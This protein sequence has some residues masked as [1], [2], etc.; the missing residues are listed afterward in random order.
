M[1]KLLFTIM[2]LV[3]GFALTS[4]SDNDDD[5]SI[6]SQPLLS[7]GSVITGSADVTSTQALLHGTVAGL[8]GQSASA[9]TCGFYYGKSQANLDQKVTANS[10][11]EFEASI[12]G[13]NADVFYYQAFVTLQGRVTYKGE[14]KSLILTD[15][16]AITGEVSDL[17]ANKA[18]FGGQLSQ[19]PA[20]AESGIVVS[21][22]AGDERV[23]AGVR[24][25]GTTEA[26]FRVEAKGFLPATTYYYTAYLDLGAGVVYGETRQFI[27]PDQTFDVNT[28]MVDLGL[29]TKWAK[30][31]LG[32]STETEAGALLGFG[33]ITGFNTGIMLEE[34]AKRNIYRTA[35]DVANRVWNGRATMP[36]ID[37]YEELFRCCKV[38]WQEMDGVA[39]YRFTGPN[40]NS[41]FMPAAGS[42]TKANISGAG[43]E[44]RYLSGSSNIVSEFDKEGNEKIISGD[45]RFAMSYLFNASGNNRTTTPTYQALSVRPVSTAKNIAFEKAK[46]IG[47]WEIDL[48]EDGKFQVF[49]GPTYFYGAD[50]SWETVTNSAP[51]VGDSWCWDADF[52]GN[53]W[54]VGGS[55]SNCKG[56]MTFREDG[57]VEVH[58]ISADG[59]ETVENGTYTINEDKKSIDFEGVKILAPTNF[60]EGYT[61]NLTTGVRILSLTDKGLQLGVPRTNGEGGQLSVNYIHQIEKY[62]YTAKLTC[63]GA[64]GDHDASDGWDSAIITIPGGND[65][66][67]TYTITFHA[68]EARTNGKVYVIDIPDFATVYPN[69]FMRVDAIKADGRDV[70]FDQNKFYFG[71]IEG[72]GTYRIEM[73]NI[74][75][76]GHNDS[77]DG[78]GDSPFRPEGGATTDETNLGFTDTFEVTFT[79][80]SLD[81]NLAFNVKQS[82]VGL[83][84]PWAMPGNWGKENP[85]A[86]RVVLGDDHKYRVEGDQL[87]LTLT[88]EECDGG[89]PPS[90]GAMN[91]V[92]VVGIRN[93]FPAFAADLLSVTC[94][95]NNVPF[96]ASKLI[97]GDI[98]GNGNYRIE[99]HNIWGA[100]TAADP[101]FG[102]ARVVEGNNC[103][104]ALGFTSS[105]VYTIGNYSPKLFSTPW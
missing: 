67:G 41:I 42:R 29:S 64:N 80:V 81:A 6:S 57:T 53:T 17:T 43:T 20:D 49:H 31:N 54:A 103:V 79:I 60:N 9:Y 69:A 96:D 18:T 13:Q 70:P 7:E 1:K 19:F 22:I 51:V 15:A 82:A 5:Y 98:E 40:G 25:P 62:G 39:G 93:Y 91:V 3:V 83:N 90:N 30:C 35:L 37:E 100:G 73:A 2:S 50:D 34:Y 26:D 48:T 23:R 66:I 65:A 86:L 72:G 102:G 36:T 77:W 24:F 59:I 95:G 75:G 99:L 78:L 84:S 8:D 47:T 16:K 4:C 85:G 101:A 92:D 88:A 14:V 63:Y 74:W 87:A 104:D 56:S 12:G 38:E 89:T 21:G 68:K 61:S 33:D 52:A 11:A 27:T 71:N 94:D 45:E 58:H 97:T 32:A 55:A 10:G 28:D 44:G 46:L 76:C 105:T